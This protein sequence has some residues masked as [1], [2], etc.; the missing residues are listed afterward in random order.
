MRVADRRLKW[1]RAATLGSLVMVL[2]TSL[3]MAG[4]GLF[5]EPRTEW[6]VLGAIGIFAFVATQA[7]VLYAA[8]T[9]VERRWLVVPFA[10]AAVA[11]VPLVGPL[12][13][14]RWESW[15]WLGGTLLGTAPL[16]ARRWVAVAIAAATLV[17]AY[18]IGARSLV[19]TASVGATVLL[20]SGLQVW[21]WK[22]LVDAYEG[23]AAQARLEVAE[24]RL[25]FARD[26]HDLLGHRLSVIALKAELAAR[27]AAAD[28][29]RAGQ[30]AAEV[31]ELAAAALL[32]VREAVQGYRRVDLPEQLSAI[33]RV[34]VS[35]G[36]RCTVNDAGGELPPEV[37]GQLVAAVREAS[38][39]VL[40]HSTATWCTIDVVRSGEEVLMTV[41]NDG[42]VPADPDRRSSGL[43]GLAERLDGRLR[44]ELADGVFTLDVVVRVMP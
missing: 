9:P 44:T 8:V 42:A 19:I 32:D 36:V 41:A 35:S 37:S 1:A 10:I 13:A 31:R 27:L 30:E 26:V 43:R 24:E 20:I 33:E 28:P 2:L 5:R 38:T 21:L 11:S 3:G 18:A 29:E 4:I 15:A 40:R 7:G 23:R 25:R 39:N 16:L 14:G 6:V 12:A 34:L 22:L 17:V